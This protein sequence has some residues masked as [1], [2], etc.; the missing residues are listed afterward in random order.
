MQIELTTPACLLLG[1]VALDGQTCQ[2][3]VTLQY[4]PI[5]LL[6]RAGATLWI[7]GG[8]A[9]LASR[10]AARFLQHQRLPPQAE[11][12]IE[13][14][15][16][17]FMG[18]GSA[19]MLGLSMARAL[20]ELHGLPADDAPALARAVGL[21]ALEALETHA[22]AQ[23]GLLLVDG[24]GMLRQRQAIAARDEADDWVFV[25]FLP[26]VPP[27]APEALE[28][29]RRR[30]LHAAAQQLGTETGRICTND[31]WPAAERNDIAAFAQALTGIQAAN[32]AALAGAGHPVAY[33]PDEHAILDLMRDGGALAYG[34]AL[35]G[36]ALYGLIKG[37][38]PSRELRRAISERVGMFGGTVMASICDNTGSRRQITES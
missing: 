25:L 18:L 30:V 34:R 6:A 5:Q 24:D 26:R 37:G 21:E 13:L 19:A 2:L 22:F 20:A 11:V 7:T 33:T 12:E 32:H 38:G 27:G 10:Q 8:R 36:L 23:G 4:P 35:T 14:A 15:I 3:G 29:D 9:D 1:L 28:A 31:L 16:P 17:S